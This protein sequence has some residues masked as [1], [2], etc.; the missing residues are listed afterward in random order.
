M[1]PL[2]IVS[3]CFLGD[4]YEVHTLDVTGSIIE[5]YQRGR[6]LPGRMEKARRLALC[7]HYEFIEVYEHALRA[8]S[9]N[10]TVA[11]LKE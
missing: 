3:K 1:G 4:P 5:H 11:T 6:A 9:T 8:V 7:G 2:G 10:G